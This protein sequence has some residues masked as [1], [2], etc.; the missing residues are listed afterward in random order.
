MRTL[1][2]NSWNPP[3]G[4]ENLV[5]GNGRMRAVR[6]GVLRLS[7]QFRGAGLGGELRGEGR[8]ELR[9]EGTHEGC[10][11]SCSGRRRSTAARPIKDR[12]S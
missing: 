9:D 5:L 1:C 7:E 2:P 4:A 11:I 12:R 3:D 6:A 8:A 10:H